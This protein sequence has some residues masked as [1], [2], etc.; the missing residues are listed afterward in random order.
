MKTTIHYRNPSWHLEIDTK[1]GALSRL[2]H[3]ADP[4]GMNWVCSP[5]ENLWFPGSSSWGLG[6]CAMPSTG[7]AAAPRWQLPV[8]VSAGK[9]R[10]RLGQLEVVVSRRL[11]GT[12]F[13]EEYVFRNTGKTAQPIWGIG[14]FTPFNDNYPDAPTCVTRRCNAHIWCGGNVAYVC[15]L[16]MGG[17]A[18]HLGLVLTDGFI[19]GYSIEGRGLLT[20]GSNIRGAIVLNANGQTLAPGQSRR[21]AWTMF[22]HTGWED[23]F[24]QARQIPGFV[25]VRAATYTV[26]GK[27]HPQI[28]VS[29]SGARIQKPDGDTIK[30]QLPNNRET[31]LRVQR[32]DD[33]GRLVQQRAKFIAARQQVCDRRDRLYGALLSYDNDTQARFHNPNW[34]DQSEGREHVGMG[35]LLAQVSQ[36]WPNSKIAAAAQLNHEFVRTKL[37]L[38]NGTVLDSVGDRKTQRL[39]NYP[40]VAQ[41]HLEMQ[42][43]DA[44][45][46]TFRQYYRRGGAKFY[47]FPI[48]MVAAVTAF[49]AA[50][51][52][53][54]AAELLKL[55]CG[56]A[57][58]VVATGTRIPP[59]EVNYEQTIVAPATLIPLEAYLL[60]KDER[61]LRCAESFLPL[62]NAF[63][64]RQPDHH[65]NDIAIRHWDGFWF[66]RLKMWG[67]T[68]PHYWSAA[69]AWVF[70]RYW[71]A[72]GSESYHQRGREILL[73]NL[74]AFRPDGSASCAYIYPDAVNGNSGRLRDPLANDQDWALVFLMQAARIDPDFVRERWK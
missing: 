55:F 70:Y 44:C 71:Q 74:S 5:T 23:F 47:A 4:H 46:R 40:W 64:G 31:W 41:F 58:Q 21:I 25:D 29:M 53:R 33:V 11:H 42:A 22:W 67:D 57:D 36:R 26:T 17:T 18:P 28:S 14:L 27:Q 43:Y 10:Y 63:N 8:K 52:D 54:Q 59:H 56:H 19:S 15:A 13:D 39:Y 37:Q 2:T 12:H 34:R 45:L 7:G 50:G 9:V 60:T 32:I 20:G 38:P 66:G 68:F 35:V 61:Y 73:N 72:T 24:A 49:R 65:L 1:T 16:R 6:Y 51:R 48:P 62:L 30:V 69:T 3:P